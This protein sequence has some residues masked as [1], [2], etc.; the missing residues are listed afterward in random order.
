MVPYRLLAR[1]VGVPAEADPGQDAGTTGS[2]DREARPSL[3]DAGAH[4]RIHQEDAQRTRA[5]GGQQ[6]PEDEQCQRPLL[7][8]VAHA[9]A[10]A[11][12]QDQ[13]ACGSP[14]HQDRCARGEHGDGAEDRPPPCRH[15]QGGDRQ[16]CEQ[17]GGGYGRLL[18]AEREPETACR[19][20]PC[21]CRVHRRLR[22]RVRQATCGHRN[23]HPAEAACQLRGRPERRRCRE[24]P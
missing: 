18:E 5:R 15:R 21:E 8:Q 12:G 13:V 4:R 19:H 14:P 1:G 23:E 10:A 3:V 17:G 7:G 6:A 2:G 11:L 16:P 24:N 20:G 9:P 22:C